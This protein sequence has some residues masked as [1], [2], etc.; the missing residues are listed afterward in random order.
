MEVAS[1]S[2]KKKLPLIF[3]ILVFLILLMNNSL[4][5]FRSKQQLLDYNES[6]I[7][8]ITQEVA[9]QVENA[10]EGSLY[11]ED[12]IGRELR[13][14]SIAI[15]RSLP[16]I[17]EDVTNEK[18]IQLADELMLSHITLLIKTEDD[19]VGVKSS[20]PHEINMGT[21]GWG[22]WYD[23]FEQLL[24]LSPVDVGEGQTLPHYW[25]GP[26]EVASSNPDHFDKWGYYYDGSTN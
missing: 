3:T 7:D 8:M 21:K 10:K 11:V 15:Q 9:F 5:F 24:A 12:L 17:H 2:I 19:I 4:H 14:A 1:L 26:I 22:Y 25:S 18:L 6:Q 23:A 20:D 13:T 16:T